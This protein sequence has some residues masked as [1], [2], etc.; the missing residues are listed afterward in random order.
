V[1]KIDLREKIG[2]V[3]AVLAVLAVTVYV[4]N[5]FIVLVVCPLA[6]WTR[7]IVQASSSPPVMLN[8]MATSFA[9]SS[10]ALSD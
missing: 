1:N 6:T 4:L 9:P 5:Y 2:H 3:S 10:N 8:A 7:L